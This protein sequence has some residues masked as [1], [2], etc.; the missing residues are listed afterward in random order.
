MI[1]A[2]LFIASCYVGSI[3]LMY[4][5]QRSFQYFPPRTGF[6]TASAYGLNG[7]ENVVIRTHDGE[8]LRAWYGAPP[9]PSAPVIV[10]LHGN[11]GTLGDRAERFAWFQGEGFGVLALSWRGYGGSTGE[12]S[13]TG[14]LTDGRSALAFLKE[15]GITQEQLIY[16]GESLGTGVAVQL[17]A[18]PSLLPAAVILDAPFT[19]AVDVARIRY[20]FMPVDH[21]MKDQFRSI[22]FASKVSAPVFILHGTADRIVPFSQGKML[23]AAFPGPKQLFRIEN[24]KHVEPLNPESWAAIKSFLAE[25]GIAPGT[26]S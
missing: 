6:E 12:P 9:K 5:F 20:W 4:L 21:L 19:S 23:Y 25:N 8:T 3:T 26:G 7:F 24:G 15:K 18:E 10:Y 13:Q 14:L 17:A 2:A 11:A 16:F 22:D 1:S